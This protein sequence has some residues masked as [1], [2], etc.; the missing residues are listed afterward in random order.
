MYDVCWQQQYS[1]IRDHLEATNDCLLISETNNVRA[2]DGTDILK[3]A[4]PRKYYSSLL[5]V[6]IMAAQMSF[7][8]S[9]FITLLNI[10]FTQSLLEVWLR[11]YLVSFVIGFPTALAASQFAKKMV[12]R[13]TVR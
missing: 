7:F 1:E 3:K 11:S 12:E 13:I 2:G 8:M 4:I 5:F 6:A 10:G 9:L